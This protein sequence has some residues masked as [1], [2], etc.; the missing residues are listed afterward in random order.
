M[1]ELIVI[2]DF[3][4]ARVIREQL[5][6]SGKRDNRLKTM[7]YHDTFTKEEL[8]SITKL[9]L[10]DGKFKD[11]SSLKYLTNL[12]DL[13]IDSAN[14]KNISPSLTVSESGLTNNTVIQV[15][16]LRYIEGAN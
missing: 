7:I 4:L 9:T 8:E 2:E 10:K 16:L 5:E 15:M 3:D 13:Q 12:V 14:A 1:N 11:I 6:K